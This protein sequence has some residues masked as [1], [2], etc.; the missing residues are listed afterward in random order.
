MYLGRFPR[1]VMSELS[2]DL[3]GCGTFSRLLNEPVLPWR[4]FLHS[5]STDSGFESS[6]VSVF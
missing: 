4:S 3:L 2:Q 6:L 5:Q 1:E